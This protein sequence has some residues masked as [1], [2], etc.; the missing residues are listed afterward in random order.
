M[1]YHASVNVMKIHST[2]QLSNVT[3]ISFVFFNFFNLNR[4]VVPVVC[5]YPPCNGTSHGQ[6]SKVRYHEN[7][8]CLVD[9]T[10]DNYAAK[11][12]SPKG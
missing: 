1:T 5:I 9:R 10:E 12:C 6:P 4:A 8:R 2:Y 7:A 11:D 3:L